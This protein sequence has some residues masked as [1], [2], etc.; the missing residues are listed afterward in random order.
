MVWFSRIA[1]L[2]VAAGLLLLGGCGGG[3]PNSEPK[4][5]DPGKAPPIKRGTRNA[6]DT[7]KEIPDKPKATGSAN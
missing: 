2:G 6:A 5:V 1:L 7:G 3:A 4:V